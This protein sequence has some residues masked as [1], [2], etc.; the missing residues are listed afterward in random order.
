M[1]IL[2]AYRSFDLDHDPSLLERVSGKS[3]TA[4]RIDVEKLSSE[5]VDAALAVAGI[6]DPDLAESQVELLR[7]P[8]HLYLFLGG[9]VDRDGFGSRRDLFGRYWD[10]KRRRVDALTPIGAFTAAVARI[11]NVLSTRRQLQTPLLALTGHEAALDAMAS[12]GVVV[13]DGDRFAFFHAS[14][15][16]YAAPE[17]SANACPKASW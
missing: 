6:A 10:E 9:G 14:F 16:D 1:R 12:E 13:C 7:T 4:L 17:R 15:F 11:S 2:L 3:P 5:D 8:L